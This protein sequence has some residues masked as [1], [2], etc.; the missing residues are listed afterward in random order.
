MEE[1]DGGAAER[2]GHAPGQVRRARA[3]RGPERRRPVLGGAGRGAAVAAAGCGGTVA[4]VSSSG[5]GRRHWRGSRRRHY[6]C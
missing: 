5:P 1:S 6:R 3:L 4:A 2:L